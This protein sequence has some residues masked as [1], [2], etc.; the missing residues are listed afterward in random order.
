[1]CKKKKTKPK[2]KFALKFFKNTQIS[3]TVRIKF[4]IHHLAFKLREY[5]GHICSFGT[6]ST[7]HINC[8][9]KLLHRSILSSVTV[10]KLLP[11]SCLD[12]LFLIVTL[13]EIFTFNYRS[14][15]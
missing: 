2:I 8:F 13:L 5:K 3:Q 11:L 4:K 14:K 12:W 10:N 6:K 7:S 1:M 15:N 9:V